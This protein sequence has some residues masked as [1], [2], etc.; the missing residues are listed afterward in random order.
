MDRT[1]KIYL[2]LL[3]IFLIIAGIIGLYTIVKNSLR[4]KRAEKK[5]VVFKT[6]D[7]ITKGYWRTEKGDEY[8]KDLKIED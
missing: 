1:G 2:T 3:L 5:K 4:D 7:G 8:D 6:K